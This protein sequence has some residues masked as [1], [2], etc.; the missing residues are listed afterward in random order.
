MAGHTFMQVTPLPLEQLPEWREDRATGRF[1]HR[2]GKFFTVEGLDVRRP[3]GPV[4]TWSQPIINQPETGV[5]GILLK[6]VGGMPYL[7]M[8]AK[9]EPG[10]PSGPQVS[11]TVQATR[12]NY[13]RVHQGLPVPYLEHFLDR[14]GRV[15]ADVRQSEQGAWFYRKR[16]RN[17]VVEVGPHI[18]AVEGFRWLSLREV[19]ELL[20]VPDLVNMDARTV[21]ACLPVQAGAGGREGFAADLARS[22]DP[23][24]G[25]RH[26]LGE[27]LSWLS[28]IRSTVEIHTRPSRLDLL[29]GWR[30]A[31]GR[32]SHE[33][34]RFFDVIGVRVE[35]CGREVA[36]WSQPMIA[37]VGTGLVAFL[38]RRI[39]G[40]LHALVHA[41]VEPG[42]TDVVELA[43]TVQCTPGNYDHLP[44]AARPLLVDE[45]MAAPP[46]RIRYDTMLSEE[47]GRFY[48]AR[49]RYVVVETDEDPLPG[50]PSFHWVAL[51]QLD[52]LLRHSYYLNVQARTLNACLHSL[53]HAREPVSAGAL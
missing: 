36:E 14:R 47:G 2:S 45:V 32:I 44:A 25:A 40:V 26:G 53:T 16:N 43:P 20:A 49:N 37:P 19:Y 13:T 5:L 22:R 24:A 39:D 8:Q 15:L 6:R 35:A 42:Y 3:G 7:L 27:I 30:R 4:P 46:H 31:E 33:T 10:N 18:E 23:R 12:S 48:R 34:G 9:N 1:H 29:R 28:D 51:H 50:H 11:P 52:E 17:I 21:L 38:V 41:R